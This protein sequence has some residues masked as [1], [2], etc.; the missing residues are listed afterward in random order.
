MSEAKDLWDRIYAAFAAHQQPGIDPDPQSALNRV[1]A[2][3]LRSAQ[4][5]SFD[6]SNCVVREVLISVDELRQLELYHEGASP[7]RDYC[8]IVILFYEGRRVVIDG[9]NRVNK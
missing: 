3:C 8:P 5:R 6:P 1:A 9:N 4:R 7:L 2:K